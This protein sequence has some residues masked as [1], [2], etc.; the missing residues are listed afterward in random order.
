MRWKIMEENKNVMQAAPVAPVVELPVLTDVV[1][2]RGVKGTREAKSY[3]LNVDII[4]HTVFL[5]CGPTQAGKTTFTNYLNLAIDKLGITFISLSSDEYREELLDFNTTTL[6]LNGTGDRYSDAMMA[7]SSQ[8]F[9][10]LESDLNI[11]TSFPINTEIVVVDTTGMDKGFRDM[12][13]GVAEKNGYKLVLVT[14]EYKFRSDYIREDMSAETKTIVERS[15]NRYRTKVL[16]EL[17]GRDFPNRLRIRSK[18]WNGITVSDKGKE[19]LELLNA[20]INLAYK[21]ENLSYL[22]NFDP[23]PTWAVI[24]DSHECTE[25]LKSLIQRLE[26]EVPGVR[27]LHVG[28]YLDKGGDTKEMVEYMYTRFMEGDIILQGNHEAYVARRLRKEISPNGD[29]EADFFTSIPVLLADDKLREKFFT[30]W[31]N[32]H[33]FAVLCSNP[34]AGNIPVYV[35][36]APCHTKYL[37]KVHFEAL[38]AQRN[39]RIADRSLPF[40]EEFAWLY[41]EANT[42]H[43]LHIFGHVSHNVT[44]KV[45]GY[46][47]K[48]KI[49]IDSGAVHGHDLSAVIIKGGKVVKYISVPSRDRFMPELSEK[50][51]LP[52]NFGHGFRR[53]FDIAD[54]ELDPRE[55]RLLNHIVEK[56]IKYI[57]GTMSPAPSVG[58][59]LEPLQ[60]AFDW[61]TKLG[62]KHV[63]L[64]PKFMGSRCQM[65][66]F[67]EGPEKTFAT[68]R[69]GWTIRSLHGQTDE[70]YKQFLASVWEN[71]KDMIDELG[72]MILDG[73]LLPW[74]ALGE[75]LIL[76]AFNPY[77][78]LVSKEL[79]TLSKDEGFK[80]LTEFGTKFNLEGKLGHL[81]A[82]KAEL[83]RYSSPGEPKFAPFDILWCTKGLKETGL[84]NSFEKFMLLNESFK[85]LLVQLDDFESVKAAHEYFNTVTSL[86]QMEGVVVKP[87]MDGSCD[88][89][90]MKVRSKEYLRLAYGYD[91][92]DPVRYARLIRQKNISGKVRMSITEHKLGSGML[93]AADD[94]KKELIVKMIGQMKEEKS[95]DPRL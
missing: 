14:F 91:Y 43:P 86:L 13:R 37:S 40:G 53:A 62:V 71:H 57:S 35:T 29:L 31:D 63:V 36:H 44:D 73:E 89:P 7:V 26:I 2:V 85:A 93:T 77:K 74:Y 4:P 66:L 5:L 41:K 17:G 45:K 75:G 84:D 16:P 20:C 65:Y 12:V 48:N 28:D 72:D 95:L 64:Q 59:E 47:F 55:T 56:G 24:G 81:A 80:A 54:Y 61:Y 92:L 58:D 10:R 22:D 1:E 60:G 21:R 69:S 34:E 68:S 39:Y 30:L 82:F 50:N 38:K 70:Q 8:A 52:E 51:P 49:F 90:Y 25:E 76:Q 6:S 18:N 9:A 78:D 88:L 33:P 15:V 79:E 94:A 67:K 83:A 87:S 27:I 11:H 46:K 42:I 19:S 32:S 23:D 3:S